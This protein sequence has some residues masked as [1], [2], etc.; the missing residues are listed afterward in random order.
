MNKKITNNDYNILQKQHDAL[1]EKLRNRTISHKLFHKKASELVKEKNILAKKLYP[2]II[3]IKQNKNFYGFDTNGINGNLWYKKGNGEIDVE[4][5]FKVVN[6]K[7]T[8]NEIGKRLGVSITANSF[9]IDFKPTK[10]SVKELIEVL[11]KNDYKYT[12]NNEVK[13]IK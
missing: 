3:N 1:I 4:I 6:G 12:L 13:L 10:E 7:Y 2:V 11:K 8:P 5:F 9:T